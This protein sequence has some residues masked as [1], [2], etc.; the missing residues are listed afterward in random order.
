MKP[1]RIEFEAF[2]SYPGRVEVDFTV[3]AQRGLFVV[4]GPTG[5]G[6]TTI[7]DAMCFALYGVMPRKGAGEVRSHHADAAAETVVRFD[8]ECDG[9]RYTATRSPEYERPA[10]RGGKTTLERAQ[11]QLVRHH[12][13]GTTTSVATKVRAVTDECARLLGLGAEQFQR[14]VL[15]P[16]GEVARFLSASSDERG[17]LL[18]TLFGGAVYDGLVDELR[19]QSIAWERSVA[20]STAVLEGKLDTAEQQI[21]RLDELLGLEPPEPDT[22]EPD[23]PG[24]DTPDSTTSADRR[25]VLVA[26]L[27]A[28]EPV[29]QGLVARAGE[30]KDRA[31]AA[32]QQHRLDEAAADRFDQYAVVVARRDELDQQRP[33]VEAAEAQAILSARARP[34]ATAADHLVRSAQQLATARSQR[35]ALQEQLDAA[36]GE[37]GIAPA[38][39][40]LAEMTTAV[41]ALRA[42]LERR[43]QALTALDQAVAALEHETGRRDQLRN[44]LRRVDDELAAAGDRSAAIRARLDTLAPLLVDRAALARR[45][46]A[47]TELVGQRRGLDALRVKA[48]AA[49]TAAAA[50]TAH[51]AELLARFVA[52][53][54]PRLATQ[55]VPGEPCAVCGSTEHPRPAAADDREP[56][57][58]DDVDAAAQHRERCE[59]ERNRLQQELSV[60]ADRL[61]EHRASSVAELQMQRDAAVTAL[62]QADAAHAEHDE[63][64]TEL[65]Q[66]DN[67]IARLG[68]EGSG[69]RGQLHELDQVVTTRADELE[70]ARSAA[71]GIDPVELERVGGVTAKLDALCAEVPGRDQ[72]LIAADATAGAAE[73]ALAAAIADGS[74]GAVD[75]A[76]AALLEPDDEQH[77]REAAG[78]LRD[79]LVGLDGSVRMLLEQG[80]PDVRPDTEATGRAAAEATAAAA[81]AA[82]RAVRAGSLHDEAHRSL[83]DHQRLLGES[84]QLRARADAAQRAYR[85][86]AHGGQLRMPLRRWVLAQELDRVT[87]AANVHLA[88][89]TAGRYSL[90]RQIGVLDKRKSSGLELEVLDAHTGRP[91]STSSLSGGEQFQ[92]SLALALGLADVVSHGGNASGRR[93]EA[94]FV[95]EGFGSLD[96]DALRDAIDT[97]HQLQ[98][99]GR[100]VGAITHV[101]AMKQE[102]HVGIEVVRRP[103]GRGSTLVVNP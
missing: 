7:F 52:T 13:D 36:F 15:L 95:D 17:E 93:F 67:E 61:G 75:E 71:A 92:A 64:T 1:L 32:T 84:G 33:A 76:R 30:L 38:P 66:L 8:F 63:L 86:C 60:V 28:S 87:A 48:D 70:V 69:V 9:V 103:D 85:V 90:Q 31:T 44:D 89:M 100:M 88:R 35:E 46:E 56:T 50:A 41:A 78:R 83:A 72:A 77:R 80:V 68:V 2:G 65:A 94:L 24:P 57:S 20:D 53:E 58:F 6:K 25:S 47:L 54:A 34:V 21:G 22:P 42:D 16:Q 74:F 39:P 5:T 3:L 82:E 4:T 10:K 43:R 59:G 98:A 26:R 101:E 81:V 96:Q 79:E 51:H 12:D 14:V 45:I 19:Q 99:T 55:L 102:L 23:T 73:S 91:R 40:S 37:G 97:L 62:D 18:G 27:A 11:A 49:A 29:R